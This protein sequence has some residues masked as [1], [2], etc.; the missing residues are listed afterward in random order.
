MARKIARLESDELPNLS[1]NDMAVVFLAPVVDLRTLGQSPSLN[2]SRDAAFR[3]RILECLRE[4]EVSRIIVGDNS[5][6]PYKKNA[7]LRRRACGNR[8]TLIH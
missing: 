7:M 2:G 1:L 8:R 5:L 3:E 6:E 4:P